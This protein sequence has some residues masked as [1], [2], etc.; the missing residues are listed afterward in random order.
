MKTKP[1]PKSVGYKGKHTD[2]HSLKNTLF[3]QTMAW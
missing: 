1:T 2:T 3:K